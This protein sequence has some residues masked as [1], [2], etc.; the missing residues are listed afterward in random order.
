MKPKTKPKT[1]RK[2]KPKPTVW[3]DDYNN[4]CSQQDTEDQNEFDLHCIAIDFT[5]RLKL[6]AKFLRCTAQILIKG[7]TT[8]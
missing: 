2:P 3:G 8:I 7:S 5:G 6:A 1:K 4:F